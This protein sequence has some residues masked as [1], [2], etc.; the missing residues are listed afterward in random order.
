MDKNRNNRKD[1]D[2]RPIGDFKLLKDMGAN[3]LRLYHHGYSKALLSDLH[4]TYGIQVLMG[5]FLGA[6][7]VGSGADWYAGTDY[8]DAGQQEKMMASVREMVAAYKD[9]P[10]VI[11]WVLGN[12]NNYGNANN[13]R[14]KQDAYYTFVNKVALLIKSLDPTRPVALC[15]GDL[16]FLDKVAKFCPDVDIYGANACRGRHG[17]GNSFWLN[18]AEVWGKPV[19]VSEFGCPA[20]HHRRPA[21]VAEEMQ[22]EYLHSNWKDIECNVAGSPGAGNALGGVLFEWV[23]E[24][25]KAGPPPQYNA[26]IQDIVGQF[27]GPFPDGWSYEEWYGVTSQGNGKHSPFLRHLRKAYFVFKDTLWNARKLNERGMPE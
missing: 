1:R 14:Q 27:G 24:W 13:S 18:V 19:F 8:T 20:Y 22:A 25:W 4:Q 9:E 3:A 16:L 15:N 21:A 2:E 17:F 5:D 6:Y 12:E 11:L 26:S 7:T 10:Y 23:D